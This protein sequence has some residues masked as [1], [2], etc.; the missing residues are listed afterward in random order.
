MINGQRK[1]A[2]KQMDDYGM[3]DFFDDYAGFLYQLYALE[4]AFSYLR[5]AASSYHRI[6]NR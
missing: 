2:V 5:D 1:Q 3:Y 4:A 6:K